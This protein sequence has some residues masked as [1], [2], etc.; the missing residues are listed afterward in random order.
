MELTGCVVHVGCRTGWDGLCMVG[1]GCRATGQHHDD[2]RCTHAELAT[3]CSRA[4][5]PVM[6]VT[7]HRSTVDADAPVVGPALGMVHAPVTPAEA[8][9]A[10]KARPSLRGCAAFRKFMAMDTR[11]RD[12]HPTASPRVRRPF[13]HIRPCS[14]A[15]HSTPRLR[16]T[17]RR[18]RSWP[19]VFTIL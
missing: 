16:I 15:W 14:V 3:F 13:F 7:N 6:L 11:C 5:V 2:R 4:R 17:H 9:H 10:V 19:V 18:A 1:S 12:S 8:W